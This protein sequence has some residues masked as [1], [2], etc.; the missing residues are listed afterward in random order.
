[1]P[2]MS[3]SL[4]LFICAAVAPRDGNRNQQCAGEMAPLAQL[5]TDLTELLEEK[6]S[7]HA[8]G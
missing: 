6:M 2:D 3:L 4:L 7:L 1:M 5:L 8:D